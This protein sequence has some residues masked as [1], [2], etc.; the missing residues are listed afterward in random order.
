MTSTSGFT[1]A[2]NNIRRICS[3]A[4]ARKDDAVVLIASVTEAQLYLLSSNQGA[5]EHAQA[6]LATARSLQLTGAASKLPQVA[7]YI[8]ILDLLCSILGTNVR[9]ARLKMQELLP[10]MEPTLNDP[11]WTDESAVFIP[12]HPGSSPGN[13]YYSGAINTAPDG[14]QRLAFFWIPKREMR[15]LICLIC[16]IATGPTTVADMDQAEQLFLQVIHDAST[17]LDDN[18]HSDSGANRGFVPFVRN[19][20]PS[21]CLS[22]AFAQQ[23]RQ[24]K[25]AAYARLYLALLLASQTRWDRARDLLD[26][27]SENLDSLN[28]PESHVLASLAQYVSGVVYQGTGDLDAALQVFRGSTFDTTAKFCQ[29]PNDS[30]QRTRRDLSILANLNIILILRGQRHRHDQSLSTLILKME[31]LCAVSA[32]RHIHSALNFIKAC[33]QDTDSMIVSKRY[34]EQALIIARQLSNLQLICIAMN[35]LN[36]K[37]LRGV[38]GQQAEK[39]ARAAVNTASNSGNQL[40]VSVSKGMLADTL[41]VQGKLTEART[42]RAEAKELAETVSPGL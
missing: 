4:R 17:S 3:I 23:S 27:S 25:L 14:I 20:E 39:G 19:D 8:R 33:S 6:A 22:L 30:S 21:Q 1:S 41:E 40:W 31:P 16:G 28:D 36:W 5:L 34:L 12:I 13:A 38:V 35:F 11:N 15:M 24:R 37:F 42:V 18:H 2:L 32:N 9:Q 7:I 10:I 26:R 29:E